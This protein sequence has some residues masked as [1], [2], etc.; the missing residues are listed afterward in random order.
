MTEII[1]TSDISVKLVQSVGDDSMIVAAA[2]VSTSG[3][4]ALEFTDKDANYGLINYLVKQ[5]HGTP[6]EHNSFTFFVDAPIFCWREHMRHRVAFSFNEASG[7]YKKLDPKFWIPKRERKF[8]PAEGYKA[9]RPVFE[10]GSDEDYNKIITKLTN[11]YKQTYSDY[12]TMVEAG[13]AKEVS[14]A[15]L[16][17]GIYSQ[18]WVTCNV[19]S[20]M[21]FLSLRVH[22]KNAK[23]VSYPQAEIEEIAR[24]YEAVLAEKFPLAY[25]SYIENGRVAP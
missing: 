16:P 22:D 14:R 7:R 1:F 25:K 23:Y 10:S 4:E 17:V 3:E 20:L 8:V 24:Q 21:N 13:F 5:K 9:A 19:R 2:K 18:C 6:L 15:C 11:S 12:E